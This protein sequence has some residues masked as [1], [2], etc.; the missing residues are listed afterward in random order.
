MSLKNKLLLGTAVL[1]TLALS[2]CSNSKNEN[3]RIIKFEE[4]S[5]QLTN[6]T[7]NKVFT[8][9]TEKVDLTSPKLDTNDIFNLVYP[10][11]YRDLNNDNKVDIK[12]RQIKEAPFVDYE[13]R[14]EKGDK[15]VVE[16][17]FILK[18]AVDRIVKAKVVGIEEKNSN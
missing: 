18:R 4:L 13:N 3:V 5:N 14:Y 9:V 2:S 16:N 8:Y 10:I 12:E 7:K 1:G 6:G 11:R 15:L 17:N